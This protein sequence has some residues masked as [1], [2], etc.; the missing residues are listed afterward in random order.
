VCRTAAFLDRAEGFFF[1]DFFFG[2]VDEVCPA[3]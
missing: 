2:A 1:V 3:E